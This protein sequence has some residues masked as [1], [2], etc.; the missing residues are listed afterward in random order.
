MI[1]PPA[2]PVQTQALRSIVGADGVLT[3]HSEMMVYE[4]DG[5]TIEKNCPDIVV[6]P[7]TTEHVQRIVQLCNEHAVPFLPRGAGTSLAGGC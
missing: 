4:C 7:R 6:F 2:T 1:A 3:A 5:F